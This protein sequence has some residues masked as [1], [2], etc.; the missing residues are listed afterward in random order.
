MDSTTD[1][2]N[3]IRPPCWEKGAACPNN[4][5]AA[6]YDRVVLNKVSLGG[7]WDG[8]RLAGNRLIA[9]DRQVI[10]LERLRGLMWRDKHELSRDAYASRQAAEAGR[11][12]PQHGPKVK[13][14]IFDFPELRIDGNAA[15]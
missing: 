7:K 15:G 5:A 4:C 9:P 11:R 8:W 10:T 14:V 13:V 1:T 6:H 12:S 3:L 2:R